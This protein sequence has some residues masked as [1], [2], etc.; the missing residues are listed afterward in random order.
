MGA[1]RDQ[2]KSKGTVEKAPGLLAISTAKAP[3]HN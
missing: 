1:L 2:D 3:V